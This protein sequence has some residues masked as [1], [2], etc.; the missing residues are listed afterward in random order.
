MLIREILTEMPA[1]WTRNPSNAYLLN[2]GT[3]QFGY[4]LS[5]GPNKAV[6]PDNAD[7]FDTSQERDQTLAQVEQQVGKI[8]WVNP[9]ARAGAGAFIIR[10]MTNEKGQNIYFG[11]YLK[12]TGNVRKHQHS[13]QPIAAN[14]SDATR[15]DVND[16]QPIGYFSSEGK[17]SSK[18]GKNN[19]VLISKHAI[20]TGDWQP[21]ADALKNPQGAAANSGNVSEVQQWEPADILDPARELTPQATVQQVAARF[22][23]S[24]PDLVE[25]TQHVGRGAASGVMPTSIAANSFAT[26]YCELLHP[27]SIVSGG[28]KLDGNPNFAGAKINYSTSRSQKGYDSEIVT[29]SGEHYYISSKAGGGTNSSVSGIYEKLED[30]LKQN[31]ADARKYKKEISAIRIMGTEG[32]APKN[33]N[34]GVLQVAIDL[35][36][37]NKDDAIEISKLYKEQR[38]RELSASGIKNDI[39]AGTSQRVINIINQTQPSEASGPSP[40]YQAMYTVMMAVGKHFNSDPKMSELINKIFAANRYVFVGTQVSKTNFQ[41]T[42]RSASVELATGESYHPF[43][44]K[45]RLGFKVK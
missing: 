12:N 31:P 19:L 15:W 1:V 28:L 16:F 22:E 38:P 25:I 34:I 39:P 40:Y 11:K 14:Q 27:L 4:M 37:I 24:N 5:F 17:R 35:G 36:L 2:D 13:N 43:E 6:Y 44:A 20:K 26:K 7:K 45:K 32:V 10:D 9:A 30:Y 29:N 42:Q 23:T 33:G 41:F 18:L 8:A 3:G 21:Y